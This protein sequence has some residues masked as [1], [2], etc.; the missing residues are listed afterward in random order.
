[1]LT[2]HLIGVLCSENISL[3]KKIYDEDTGS[4]NPELGFPFPI[5]LVKQRVA[6]NNQF[7]AGLFWESVLDGMFFS[8]GGP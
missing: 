4:V 1:M 6:S 7:L 2:S 5:Q 3:Y 8:V